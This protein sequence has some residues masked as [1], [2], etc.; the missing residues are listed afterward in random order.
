[1]ALELQR[2]QIAERN[3]ESVREAAIEALRRIVAQVE[4]D[5]RI[6]SDRYVD[7]TTVPHGGE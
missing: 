2:D 6:E 3:A 1:M 5:C 7:E 4:R